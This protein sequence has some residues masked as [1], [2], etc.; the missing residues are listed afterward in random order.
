MNPI[1]K[2]LTLECWNTMKAGNWK[3][4]AVAAFTALGLW[5]MSLQNGV[6]RGGF[7]ESGLLILDNPSLWAVWILTGVVL[8]AALAMAWYLG[9][10]GSFETDFHPCFYSGTASVA[11]GLMMSCSGLSTLGSW[12]PVCAICACVMGVVMAVCGM[13]RISGRKPAWWLDMGLFLGYTV[14]LVLGYRNWNADPGVQ[15]YGFALLALVGM[16]LFSLHRARCIEGYADRRKMIF[17]GLAGLYL[18]FLAIPGSDTPE[19][20]FASGV[21]CA[22]ALSA[23]VKATPQSEPENK[24]E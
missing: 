23:L 6:L 15:E 5:G 17:F 1:M 9:E 22:G 18:S 14:V 7:D 24:T 3:L 13:C 4:A 16:V 11:A 21:W 19:F 8:L 12:K 20:Y 10:G 2:K